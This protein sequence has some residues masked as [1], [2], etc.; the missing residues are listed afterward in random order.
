MSH[1]GWSGALVLLAVLLVLGAL[2]SA[3]VQAQSHA[4]FPQTG[5][6]LGGSF[7]AF[8]ESNGAV[9]IFGYPIS[10]EFVQ[11]RDGRV[12][13]YFERARFEL[14]VVNNQAHVSLGLIGREY[15]AATGQGFP[16]VGPV[17]APGVRYFPETGHTV[18]GSFL[19][20]W[21][22]RGGLA[23]FGFPLSEELV[24]QLEDGQN[25]VVQY[26]ERARFELVGNQ[27][28]LG[29][30]GNAL[31]P[32]QLRPGVSPYAPPTGPIPEGDSSV[33]PQ[34]PNVNARAFPNPATAGSTIGFE[35]H[36]YKPG[37]RVALWLNQPDGQAIVLRY[38]AYA[39]V[40]GNLLIGFPT[41]TADPLGN[42]SIVGQGLESDTVRV[43]TFT[44]VR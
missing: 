31:V 30:L 26:F 2:P 3:P 18:R 9:E 38:R 28:R 1:R 13:Q 44:L 11:N 23:V 10:P 41:T 35:A 43:A 27:V 7:R 8:W 34:A 16:R 15:L 32:C 5:H 4:Y 21:D 40:D 6:F 20:F 36:G 14:D 19:S 39:N 37:E 24:Q 42:W 25:Y 17:S 33:C 29:S 22:R 12:A